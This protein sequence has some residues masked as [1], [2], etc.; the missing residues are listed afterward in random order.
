MERIHHGDKRSLDDSF[1]HE[2]EQDWGKNGDEEKSAFFLTFS[3]YE[4]VLLISTWPLLVHS[5][6]L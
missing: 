1:N 3:K 2:L 4:K 5:L 6:W